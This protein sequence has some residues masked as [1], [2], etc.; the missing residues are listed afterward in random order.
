VD[1]DDDDESSDGMEMDPKTAENTLANAGKSGAGEAK[2]GSK[3]KRRVSWANELEDHTK[4]AERV[5]VEDISKP[6]SK[7]RSKSR[8]SESGESAQSGMCTA[9]SSGWSI[10][11]QAVCCIRPMC[12]LLGGRSSN[13]FLL[14]GAYWLAK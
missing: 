6:K 8:P 10:F 14:A 5:Q 11:G 4:H 2:S 9:L 13:P 7:S 1:D 12:I 3:S